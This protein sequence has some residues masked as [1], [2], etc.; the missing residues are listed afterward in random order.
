MR[1]QL[2]RRG[3]MATLMVLWVQVIFPVLVG[4]GIYTLWRSRR[5]L[6][7]VW[8]RWAG[9]G[10]LV[11]Q[12]RIHAAYAKHLIP[13]P[14]LYSLPD[15]L[16]VYSF[17]S[18]M[19][20]LWFSQPRKIEKIFWTTLPVFLAVGAEAG[21]GIRLVPGT[22]DLIDVLAYLSAWVLAILS[23]RVFLLKLKTT[24]VSQE[25]EYETH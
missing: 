13:S 14:I 6:I 2:V 12:A 24:D 10:G 21:Q 19:E 1:I 9:V 22:F 20:L 15:A 3:S 18:L 25:A 5:L 4:A 7:F 16:W 17:S 11:F 23:T 8:Y